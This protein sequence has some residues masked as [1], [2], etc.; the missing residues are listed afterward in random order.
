MI[1]KC[2]NTRNDWMLSFQEPKSRSSP[3]NLQRGRGQSQLRSGSSLGKHERQRFKPKPKP[4]TEFFRRPYHQGGK[5]PTCYLRE[6]LATAKSW[7]KMTWHGF[8]LL[9]QAAELS[10]MLWVLRTLKLLAVSHKREQ[11]DPS[12]VQCFDYPC[13]FTILTNVKHRNSPVCMPSPNSQILSL[14]LSN[15]H[16]PNW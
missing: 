5:L 11:K 8:K 9:S 14:T 16:D 12:R 13:V 3:R 4:K 10:E 1:F 2:G 15:G 7:I 6:R